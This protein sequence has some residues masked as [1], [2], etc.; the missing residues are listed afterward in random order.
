MP[1]LTYFSSR[2]LAELSRLILAETGTAYEA[3]NLGVYKPGDQ[4]AAFIALQQ[5][6]KLAFGTVPLWEEDDGFALVQ[7]DAIVR[8][9]ARTRG[10]Y[11]DTAQDAARA[12]MIA[13]SVRDVRTEVAKLRGMEGEAKAA[14]RAKLE[15]SYL[16]LWMERFQVNLQ[17]SGF[18]G[19]R[20][21]YADLSAWYLLEN[22]ADNN[23]AV[24]RN[25]P[26]L[27]GFFGRV[28]DR[29]NLA[30]HIT[31]PRRFPPQPV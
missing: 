11:G 14:H 30:R 3:V 31:S 23:L 8:H 29:P 19:P 10:L 15:S 16:P 21:T 17:D 25:Y 18:F 20:F 24:W 7:S 6:G 5:S 2:G 22:L 9:L 28:H 13:E 12:D 1:R 26:A 4:P 27:Q